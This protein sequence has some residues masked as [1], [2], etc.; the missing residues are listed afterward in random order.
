MA[1]GRTVNKFTRVYV[2]GNDLSGYA[3]TVGPLSVSFAEGPDDPMNAEVVG[4][5]LGQPTVNPGTI[6]A[7]FTNGPD[8]HSIFTYPPYLGAQ[9]DL[10]VALGIQ[11]APTFGDPVFMGEFRQDDYLT[12][13]ADTPVAVTI[14]FSPS[15]GTGATSTYVNPWGVLVHPN[16]TENA[17]NTA[18]GFLNS[19]AATSDGGYMAYQ[20]GAAAGSGLIQAT[21]K[22][23]DG[24]TAA[25]CT[26]DL[27]STGVLNLGSGGVFSGNVGGIVG[28]TKT[29]AVDKYLR[30][31]VVFGA[32]G[33]AC[34]SITFVLGF[35][36]TW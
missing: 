26:H 28:L 35:S 2:N 32:G 5:W 7:L 30:W 16:A 34:T 36:R 31:Q 21:I 8:W 29:A 14:K 15:S 10:L 23:C 24:A 1:S 6:N 11:A 27:L 13:P 17:V 22:V 20:I 19:A 18:D 9:H 3:R 4:T 25:T 12:T 33:N